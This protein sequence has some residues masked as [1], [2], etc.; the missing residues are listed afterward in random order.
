MRLIPSLLAAL[1]LAPGLANA[2][3]IKVGIANDI[4]DRSRR[5]APRR[6]M[7][8]TWPSRNWAASWAASRPNS[9][10]PT[11]AAIRTRRASW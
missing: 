9:C 3:P 8:S 2:D 7:D 11:W 1:A 4:S 6:V 5:W 10:R